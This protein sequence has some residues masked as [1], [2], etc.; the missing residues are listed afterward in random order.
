MYHYDY[1]TY[2]GTTE[3]WSASAAW[4]PKNR[5]GA[6]QLRPT[7]TKTLLI[8]GLIASLVS[9]ALGTLAFGTM[10]GNQPVASAET[11]VPVQVS[12]WTNLK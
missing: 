9:I 7:S 1:G 2:F 5:E 10:K 3:M 6:T 8:V 11:S 12:G 4:T